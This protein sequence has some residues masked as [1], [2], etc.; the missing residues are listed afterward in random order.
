MTKKRSNFA[1]IIVILLITIFMIGCDNSE[2]ESNDAKK[3]VEEEERNFGNFIVLSEKTIENS[4]LIQYIMYDSK[5]MVMW[6]YIEENH[7]GGLSPMYN[8]DGTLRTYIP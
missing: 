3:I 2:K 8:S 1:I 5:T 7:G 6:T 4:H